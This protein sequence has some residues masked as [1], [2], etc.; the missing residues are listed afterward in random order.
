MMKTVIGVGDRGQGG[1][2]PPLR[3]NPEKSEL[4]G[5][6]IHKFRLKFLDTH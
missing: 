1:G 2:R 6:W 5:H 3:I 4:F